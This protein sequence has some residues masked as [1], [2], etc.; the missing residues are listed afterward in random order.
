MVAFTDA[1]SIATLDGLVVTYPYLALFTAVGAD[2]GVGFTEAAFPGYARVNTTG[3]W[4]GASGTT[5]VSKSNNGT[6][7]FPL[8]TSAGADCIAW[9]L[10]TAASGGIL[11]FWDYLGNYDWKPATFSLASPSIITLPVHNFSNGDRCVISQEMGTEGTI[12]FS[13][14]MTIAGVATDTFNVGINALNTGGMMLRKVVVQ[15]I[16]SN[17]VVRFT[18]GQLVIKL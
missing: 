16:V 8:A 7:S 15:S 4:A 6:I 12:P 10:Y 18:S 11:G 9:G 1:L 13:G 5:P 17:L 14:L 2:S 3:L